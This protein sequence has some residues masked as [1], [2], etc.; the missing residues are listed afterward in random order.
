MNNRT[1]AEEDACSLS[2]FYQ[3]FQNFPIEDIFS[4]KNGCWKSIAKNKECD[5]IRFWGG[6]HCFW[7]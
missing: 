2:W 1:M 4:N 5:E 3:Y 7:G 6:R